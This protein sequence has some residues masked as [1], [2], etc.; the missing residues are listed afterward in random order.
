M[1]IVT[2]GAGVGASGCQL[3]VLGA[4]T[5]TIGARISVPRATRL[6]LQETTTDRTIRRSRLLRS[7][8]TIRYSDARGAAVIFV[9]DDPPD[10]RIDAP[11][12]LH[13]ID[14]RAAT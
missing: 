6:R 10:G 5:A 9:A 11:L 13:R 4:K 7:P 2:A 1:P 12:A 8:L 14:P 3:R